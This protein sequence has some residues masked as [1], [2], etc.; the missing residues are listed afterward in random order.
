MWIQYRYD[1]EPTKNE[2]YSAQAIPPFMQEIIAADGVGRLCGKEVG[3]MTGRREK[4]P[5]RPAT[6]R[7]GDHRS[8]HDSPRRGFSSFRLQL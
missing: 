4:L 5:W 2:T 8:D 3:K 7:T 1:H 6:N